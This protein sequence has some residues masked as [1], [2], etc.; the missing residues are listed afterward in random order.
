MDENPPKVPECF[1]VPDCAQVVADTYDVPVC[2]YPDPSEK[3]PLT[4]LPIRS[5]TKLKIKCKSYIIQNRGDI[6]WLAVN[7]GHLQ[8]QFPPIQ[9]FYFRIDPEYSSFFQKTWNYYSQFPKMKSQESQS[10]EKARK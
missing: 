10:T 9:T 8:T 1:I 3:S 5:P 6:H 7:C 2:V 4:F